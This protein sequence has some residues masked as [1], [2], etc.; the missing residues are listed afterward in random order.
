MWLFS[1]FF[2][3]I[4]LLF[5]SRTAR[6]KGKSSCIMS[7]LVGHN[8]G[9]TP[10]SR[11]RANATVS[12]SNHV[13]LGRKRITNIESCYSGKRKAGAGIEPATF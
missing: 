3:A 5:S 1:I 8:F 6:P 11:A 10:L 12:R 2:T 7:L 13:G 4:W 9:H